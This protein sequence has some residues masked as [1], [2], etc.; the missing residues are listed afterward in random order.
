[1]PRRGDKLALPR[2]GD[3][4]DA[5]GFNALAH[6][7]LEWM[8]TRSFTEQTIEGRVKELRPFFEWCAARG[9]ARPSEL[10]RPMLERYQRHLFHYRKQNGRPL[11]FAV[12]RGRLYAV[13]GFFRYLVRHNL[14]LSNPASELELPRVPQRLPRF[15]LSASEVERVLMQ[16]DLSEPRGVRDRAIIETFYS[17]GM[18]RTELAHLEVFG[19]DVERR[20]V[21]IRQGKGQKDRVVP[22]GERA[23]AWVQKYLAE[24]RP[25][26][27]VEP[28][29]GVLFLTHTGEPLDAGYLTHL[30]R[31]YV[32]KAALGK[33][34]SCHLLRHS[35]ATL[36]LENGADVRF[37]QAL[38]G[39]AK[40]ETTQI[41][42]HVSIRALQEI[43]AATH[44]AE[45][46]SKSDESEEVT[47]SAATGAS[48]SGTSAESSVT[49][50]TAPTTS[51]APPTTEAQAELWSS[52]AAEAAEE[53]E[54]E[55]P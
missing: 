30:V 41:Y 37:I 22:I 51:S 52:L 32:E 27:V 9:L 35:M 11:G 10:T 13:R 16:P 53:M 44:P 42:T 19:V 15:V 38:L 7:Y 55:P 18:R 12:Q 24:V 28:D 21:M 3:A 45:R 8:R 50:A 1:M 29:G 46:G 43:H 40:L 26:W 49:P 33:R 6:G 4:G 5:L 20:V 36:M 14:I 47:G 48:G 2:V 54:G 25:G 39:H 31:R 34:G 23:L 17:T